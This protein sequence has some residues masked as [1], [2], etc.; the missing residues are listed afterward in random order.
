ME[1]PRF[2][3]HSSAILEL[4]SNEVV[5]GMSARQTHE[6]QAAREIGVEPD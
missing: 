5:G 6:T 1:F 2:E 3:G 4:F